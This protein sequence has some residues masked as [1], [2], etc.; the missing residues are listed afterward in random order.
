VVV[1]SVSCVSITESGIPRL[2][3]ISAARLPNRAVSAALIPASTAT[4]AE[5]LA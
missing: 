2:M 4:A 3:A 1:P 5:T